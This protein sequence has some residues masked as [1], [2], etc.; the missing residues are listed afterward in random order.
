[1]R[2]LLF[3]SLFAALLA[4]HQAIAYE[5]IDGR[6]FENWHTYS[7]VFD[8]GTWACVAETIPDS[9]RAFALSLS[10]DGVYRVTVWDAEDNMATDQGDRV[11]AE[12]GSGGRFHLASP[13]ADWLLIADIEDRFAQ[14][15]SRDQPFTLIFPSGDQWRI[16]RNGVSEALSDMYACT[17]AMGLEQGGADKRI[18]IAN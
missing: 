1:M 17:E 15:L 12:F 14:E 13:E 6:K 9:S 10:W 16:D 7:F 11:T 4:S 5:R 3:A 8:D 2:N 18:G